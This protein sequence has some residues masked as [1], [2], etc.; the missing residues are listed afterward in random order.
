[1]SKGFGFVKIGEH[2]TFP[3]YRCTECNSQNYRTGETIVGGKITGHIR[4]LVCD[5]SQTGGEF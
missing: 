1:M 3:I 2:N 5:N 4:C